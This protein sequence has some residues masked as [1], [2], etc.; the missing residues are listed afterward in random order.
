MLVE[1]FDRREPS[2]KQP[3]LRLNRRSLDSR[4]RASCIR[5]D[6]GPRGLVERG[7]VVDSVRRVSLRETEREEL[8][9]A[10][11]LT[12]FVELSIGRSEVEGFDWKRGGQL[13]KG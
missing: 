2:G 1:R 13:K 11:G 6:R 7:K 9:Q 5:V 10:R 3:K 12:K 8:D 4:G